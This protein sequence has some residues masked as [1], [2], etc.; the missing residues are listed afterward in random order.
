MRNYTAVQVF[1]RDNVLAPSLSTGSHDIAFHDVFAIDTPWGLITRVE[2]ANHLG[3][4]LF[5]TGL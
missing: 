2:V 4:K 3:T 1:T 5:K